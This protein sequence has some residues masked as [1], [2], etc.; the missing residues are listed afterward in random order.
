MSRNRTRQGQKQIMSFMIDAGCDPDEV[1]NY[2]ED[3][4]HSQH[5]SQKIPLKQDEAEHSVL[6]NILRHKR[7]SKPTKRVEKYKLKPSKSE[8]NSDKLEHEYF[9]DG[10]NTAKSANGSGENDF[11]DEAMI[12]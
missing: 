2:S 6:S 4:T 11:S 1:G 3:I 8:I 7:I 10:N 9:G 12:E 5:S